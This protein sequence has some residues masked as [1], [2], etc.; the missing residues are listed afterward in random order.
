[1]TAA[2]F[3]WLFRDF[4]SEYYHAKFGTNWTTN[5][6]ET[7][8]GQSLPVYMVP[9]YPGL[10]RVKDLIKILEKSPKYPIM[11]KCCSKH[12][13]EEILIKGLNNIQDP[14]EHFSWM[15]CQNAD[16]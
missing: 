3:L 6:G 4:V 9:K 15:N 1:M 8:G 10:N 14:Q 2:K 16:D 13:P 12:D 5:K 7:E 11:F